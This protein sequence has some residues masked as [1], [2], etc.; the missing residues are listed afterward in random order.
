MKTL[1]A[2]AARR[3][4]RRFKS[5][6]IPPDALESILLAGTQ[7]PSAKNRQ[8]WRFVVVQG[9]QRA[10]MVRVMRE[11]IAKLKEQGV[12]IGSSQGS[13]MIMEEAPVTVFIPHYSM[14]GGTLIALAADEIVLD[15]N[16]VLGP[17]DPQL[18]EYPAISI[19]S[20]LDKKDINEIDDRTLILAD[21]A[22]KAVKQVNDVV[23]KVLVANGMQDLPDAME[24]FTGRDAEPDT[25]EGRDM[26]IA[27]DSIQ[28]FKAFL[29]GLQKLDALDGE[30]VRLLM[31]AVQKDTGIKGKARWMPM[32]IA[33][34][35]EMHGPELPAIVAVFGIEKVKERIQ[36]ALAAQ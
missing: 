17:I 24:V 4:I 23:K 32:R 18:G 31:K 11:G 1:D 15:S 36:Q 33:R 34:T 2:I 20:V 21:V 26:L 27:E 13:A 6:S 19:L 22:R 9:E 10:E 8:P 28:V 14:S 25:A 35:G 3:S 12:D 5:E 30:A 29:E 7:A 16:A